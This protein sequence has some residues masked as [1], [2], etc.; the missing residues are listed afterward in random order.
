MNLTKTAPALVALLF[1]LAPAFAFGRPLFQTDFPT[2]TISHYVHPTSPHR[3]QFTDI[4][5]KPGGGAWSMA[6]IDPDP[7][8]I[9]YALKLVRVGN[10]AGAGITRKIALDPTAPGMICLRVDVSALNFSEKSSALTIDVGN[11]ANASADYNIDP[12][13]THLFGRLQIDLKADGT[14]KLKHVTN[15]STTNYA[16]AADATRCPSNGTFATISYYLSNTGA[17][18]FYRAPDGSRR[19]HRHSRRRSVERL[20]APH[21]YADPRARHGPR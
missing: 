16:Y 13:V 19:H 5:A 14:F 1:A 12:P 10:T 4:S 21:R 2:N 15:V 17:T 6:D 8:G 20:R 11:L 3:G 7:T 18:Q 9:E